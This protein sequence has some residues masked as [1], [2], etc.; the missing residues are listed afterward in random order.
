[1]LVNNA[2]ALRPQVPFEEHTDADFELA[3]RSGLWGTFHMMRAVFPTMRDQGGGRIVNIA[4][5]AGTHGRPGLAGYAAAKEGIR[6]LTKVAA[7]E[8]GHHQ[9]CVNV[10]CPS[11]ATPGSLAWARDHPEL[12]AE[13]VRQIP[14][15][16]LGDPETDIGAAV[17][18][19]AGPGGAFITGQTLMVNGGA[20][21]M[22]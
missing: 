7:N 13:A 21:I 20:T 16:R 11:A 19:L 15:G 14:L 4:S 10:I 8:W 5:S 2:Q 18:Y 3:L 22:P 6:G 12:F 9:I 1:V 17:V